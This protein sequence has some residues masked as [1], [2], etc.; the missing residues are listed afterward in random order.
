MASLGDNKLLATSTRGTCAAVHREQPTSIR[1]RHRSLYRRFRATYRRLNLPLPPPRPCR[2]LPGGDL[3]YFVSVSR[4]KIDFRSNPFAVSRPVSGTE[5]GGPALGARFS[6]LNDRGGV[7]SCLAG[8]QRTNRSEVLALNAED[9][10]LSL[11]PSHV[12]N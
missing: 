7:P 2:S 6:L 8:H 9:V 5:F 10:Y 12:Q 1:N 3:T 11:P 4:R